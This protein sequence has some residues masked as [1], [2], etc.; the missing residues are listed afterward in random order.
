[1]AD[2]TN[3]TTQQLNPFAQVLQSHETNVRGQGD[4]SGS[5]GAPDT[6][7]DPDTL[8]QIMEQRNAGD[9][10]PDE[11]KLSVKEEQEKLQRLREHHDRVNPAEQHEI[12][13][14]RE[15][16]ALRGI[17]AT[18]QEI[19]AL[20]AQ[21]QVRDPEIQKPL[22]SQLTNPGQEGTYLDSFFASLR[23]VVEK[24]VPQPPHQIVKNRQKLRSG[25]GVVNHEESAFV[26]GQMHHERNVNGGA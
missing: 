5:F 13:Q 14:A 26:Q 6:A 10:F 8:R 12:F 19:R 16:E 3:S 17:E 1:M 4:A 22:Q 25:R 15:Q 2:M 21:K 9:F 11:N 20:A 18:R 24:F 7:V 23:Q